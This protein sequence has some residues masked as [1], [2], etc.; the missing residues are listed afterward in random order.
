MADRVLNVCPAEPGIVLS[1]NPNGY[2]CHTATGVACPVGIG[3]E[4]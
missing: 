1:E 4:T 2:D 3:V